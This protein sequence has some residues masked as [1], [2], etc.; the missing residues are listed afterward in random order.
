[1]E[2]LWSDNRAGRAAHGHEAGPLNWIVIGPGSLQARLQEERSRW[3]LW[4][5]VLFAG[6]I[7]TYFHL[8]LEPPVWAVALLAVIAVGLGVASARPASSVLPAVLLIVLLGV[9]AGKLRTMTAGPGPMILPI[10]V[11][12]VRG[13]LEKLEQKPGG[14]G[15][16]LL[17]LTA[18]IERVAPEKLPLRILL[19]WRGRKQIA[20]RPGDQVRAI[21]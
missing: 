6:G 10:G 14:K 16:R 12:Q 9:S 4:V 15:F 18:E 21:E 20:L 17:L 3:F 7:A 11:V 1:M 2:D 13:W 5:P 8:P 19:T